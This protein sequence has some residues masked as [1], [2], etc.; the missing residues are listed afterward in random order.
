VSRSIYPALSGAKVAWKQMEMVSNNLA[1]A[2]SD[3]FKQHR[4]ALTSK[5]VN[6]NALGNSYVAVAET[7]HDMSDGTLE[8]TG[9]DT[10]LALRG[11]GFFVV[12]TEGGQVLQR[13]GNFRM[14]SDGELV[15]QRG[16]PVLTD[17]G[18]LEIPDRERIV[19]DKQGVVR[20]EGGGELGRLRIVDAEAVSPLGNGQWRADGGTAPAEDT[21]QVLQGAL[22]KSNADPIRGMIELVEASRYFE[23]YQK[24]MRTSDELDGRSNDLMRK[25]R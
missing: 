12:Q 23:A 3:G 1:N 18:P 22:E 17:S 13:A 16:Q 2:T 10:H 20:T 9:V 4:M 7:V 5:R 6:E 24:A 21:V 8:S 25:S 15:N 19:I 11:R 14:N